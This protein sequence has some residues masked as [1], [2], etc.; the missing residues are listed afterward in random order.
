MCTAYWHVLAPPPSQHLTPRLD[1]PQAEPSF[2]VKSTR[3]LLFKAHTVVSDRECWLPCLLLVTMVIARCTI[4]NRLLLFCKM[5]KSLL[6]KCYMY[7]W[8]Q[9]CIYMH[10][11]TLI[12]IVCLPH[13]AESKVAV[14]RLHHNFAMVKYPRS[15]LGLPHERVFK[16]DNDNLV[17]V[18]TYN[19]Y[20]VTW[21][22][23]WCTCTNVYMYIH[24]H[25]N[26]GRGSSTLL[27]CCLFKY[28]S[29]ANSLEEKRCFGIPS[30]KLLYVER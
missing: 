15:T 26:G 8:K 5:N 14:N 2:P 6:I 22:T 20:T 24:L 10:V 18:G 9:T 1:L 3:H 13:A 7:M 21:V 19:Y 4:D 27:N 16:I 25:Y 12:F 28:I 11:H 17:S 29:A 23:C 30:K